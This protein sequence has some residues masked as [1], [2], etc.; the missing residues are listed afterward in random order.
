MDERGDR[1]ARVE[2]QVGDRVALH[3]N[4]NHCGTVVAI[5]SEPSDG[6]ALSVR[7]D[8]GLTGE[9]AADLLVRCPRVELG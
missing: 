2:F 5:L 6:A 4:Q 7:W 9:I 8:Y 3:E 1:L